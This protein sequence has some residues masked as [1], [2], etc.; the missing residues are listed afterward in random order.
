[1]KKE[2][3]VARMRIQ[4]NRVRRDYTEKPATDNEEHHFYLHNIDSGETVE[5]SL[6]QYFAANLDDKNEVRDSVLTGNSL[7]LNYR[8]RQ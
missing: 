8:P 7:T 4:S 5:V 3:N 1:M 2:E 6:K